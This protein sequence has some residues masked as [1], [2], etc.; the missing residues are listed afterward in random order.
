MSATPIAGHPHWPRCTALSRLVAVAMAWILAACSP[1]A[2]ESGVAAPA[3]YQSPTG[4]AGMPRATGNT[5]RVEPAAI[6]DATGF[7][8]PMAA[9][10]LFLPYGWQT[11]GGVFWGRE[12]LCTNGYAFDWTAI[13]PDGS[14]TIA[15]L[16][17]QRWETNNYGAPPSTPGC[18]SAPFTNVRLYLENLARQWRADAR[19]LDFRQRPDI[20]RDLARFNQ[21]TPTAMGEM[22]TWAEAGELLLAYN[23]RGID[24][25]GSISAAVIFSG[26]RNSNGMGGT[27]EALT[28]TS[29]PV[30]AVA[31]P[32]GRLDLKFFEAIRRTIVANPR[33]EQRINGHNTAIGRVALEESRKRAEA[34]MRSNAEIARIRE[35]AWNTYQ[36][37][38]DRR[39]R[40]FGELMRGVETYNDA[41]APGGTVELSG[42]YSHAWRLNDGSYVLSND[43]GFDPWRDLQ[44]EGRKL[45]PTP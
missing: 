33:W 20:A 34:I 42:N 12:F 17:Q 32:N 37:S 24:M 22:R 29:L 36:V 1:Q 14:T 5:L 35:D 28:G 9:S 10:T 11:H 13:S 8:Q 25:R 4:P 6:V 18:Q 41:G 27:M 15:I 21:S 26:S 2:A 38:A 30:Y 40:E 3:G 16:P 45:S 39:A 44:L 7:E 43:A 23:D 19:V 31:A